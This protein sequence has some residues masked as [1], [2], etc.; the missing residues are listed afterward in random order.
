MRRLLVLVS[1]LLAFSAA[2]EAAH[3]HGCSHEAPC[4]AACLGACGATCCEQ[5]VAG[6][7][8]PEAPKK[9]LFAAYCE[10]LLPQL[11]GEEIFHPPAA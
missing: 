4:P 2:A 8:A 1:L 11:F 10:D 7:A 6:I 5:A 3:E 9:V